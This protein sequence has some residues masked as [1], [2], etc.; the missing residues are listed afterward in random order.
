MKK[1]RLVLRPEARH[2][3]EQ[4]VE[5]YETQ[6]PDLGRQF[7][8]EVYRAFDNIVARP[9]IYPKSHETARKAVLR[10]FPYLVFYLVETNRIV[11]VAIFHAKRNPADLT[12]RT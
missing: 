9:E 4:A 7:R 1:R 5:W 6:L 3:L 11:V 12:S 8:A 2:E 10:R